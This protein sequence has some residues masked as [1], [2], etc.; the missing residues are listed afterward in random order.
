MHSD[1]NRVAHN[2]VKGW[3]FDVYPSAQGEV[4]VWIIGENGERILL[5][6]RFEPKIYISGKTEEIERL[7]SHFY[8]SNIIASWNFTF[9]YA[10]PADMEKTKVLEVTLKDCRKTYMFSRSILKT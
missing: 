3:I 1:K 5:T 2:G 6:D 9:K 7:A 10:H 8:S 4:A